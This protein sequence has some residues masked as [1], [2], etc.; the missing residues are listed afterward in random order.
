MSP[1]ADEPA[2][3]VDRAL[4][5]GRIG[6][7]ERLIERWFPLTYA[8]NQVNRSM[9]HD[10]LYPF[11]LSDDVVAKL[12]FMHDRVHAIETGD[13]LPAPPAAA[14]SQSQSMG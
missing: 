4:A 1:R 3:T 2:L 10:D 6:S 11:A 7:F 9:G 5:A 12:A 13:E 14:Q 8:L